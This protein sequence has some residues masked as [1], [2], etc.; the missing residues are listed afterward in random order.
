MYIHNATFIVAPDREDEL[1]DWLSTR[2]AKAAAGA[3]SRLSVLRRLSDEEPEEKEAVSLA[4][5]VEFSTME[6]IE[7]WVAESFNPLVS[8]FNNDFDSNG[9]VF[10]SVSE[11]IEPRR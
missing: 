11:T 6:E 7:R 1:I 5:Q 4:F 10:C 8:E 2:V 9:V 3:V